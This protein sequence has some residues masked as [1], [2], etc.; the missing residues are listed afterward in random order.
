M[1]TL[2][3]SDVS[4]NG[5]NSPA[6]ED[7]DLE[8]FDEVDFVKVPPDDVFAFN[9]LRSCADLYRMCRDNQIE[10]QP[11]YQREYVWSNPTQTRFIDSLAKSLPIPSMCFSMDFR[12]GNWQVIDGQQRM[13]T[14]IKFLNGNWRLSKL[15]DVDD[16]LSGV[17][18]PDLDTDSSEGNPELFRLIQ[19]IENTTLPIT[20]LRCNTSD[21]SHMEY[22]FTI[23]HRLNTGGNKLNN[24]EIRNC[25]YSGPFNDL[26]NEMDNNPHWLDIHGRGPLQTKRFRGQEI[27]LRFFALQDGM[28]TYKNSL[29]RFLN[30]YMFRNRYP[31]DDFLDAKRDLFLQTVEVVWH[32]VFGETYK[33]W[34]IAILE[35]LLVGVV[36]NLESVAAGS[37]DDAQKMFETLLRSDA[38]SETALSAGLARRE[39]VEAR[40]STAIRVFSGSAL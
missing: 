16:V 2:L 39:K 1:A 23:F 37:A 31:S 33:R 29:V 20:V 17:T 14:I 8:T 40:I 30:D 5:I 34:P 26:L 12:T 10:T 13:S 15:P 11:Y 38:F 19:R 9:E 36:T 22:I 25:I 24:Q 7:T 35:A 21:P 4:N 32:K 27:I 6:L 18:I 3:Q 28:Q